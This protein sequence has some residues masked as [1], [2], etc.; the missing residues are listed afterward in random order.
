MSWVINAL[1]TQL[2][3]AN[4]PESITDLYHFYLCDHNFVEAS[5]LVL[6]LYKLTGEKDQNLLFEYLYLLAESTP[7]TMGGKISVVFAERIE[8]LIGLDR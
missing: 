4:K 5:K 8:K 6:K 2:I 3:N 7:A 1:G